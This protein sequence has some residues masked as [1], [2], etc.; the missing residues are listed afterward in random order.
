MRKLLERATFA[1]FGIAAFVVALAELPRP[2]R[3]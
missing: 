3:Y 1:A 2:K